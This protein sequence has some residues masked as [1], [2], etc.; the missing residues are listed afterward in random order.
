MFQQQQQQ[1]Q[2]SSDANSAAADP[3]QEDAKGGVHAEK[4]QQAQSDEEMDDV[5][6]ALYGEEQPVT[7]TMADIIAGTGY[8]YTVDEPAATSWCLLYLEDGSIEVRRPPQG[9]TVIVCQPLG[10][11]LINRL[12]SRP[13]HR[14]CSSQ[15]CK[16]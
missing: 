9:D 14:S 3:M 6:M 7:S 2:S 15:V 8:S 11:K 12:Y 4:S 1:Q 5:D 16:W 10:D 13:H